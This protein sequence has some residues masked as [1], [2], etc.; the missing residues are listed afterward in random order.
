MRCQ[1]KICTLMECMQHNFHFS[2]IFLPDPTFLLMTMVLIIQIG[3]TSKICELYYLNLP[4]NMAN[5]HLLVVVCSQP[6][7]KRWILYK[8]VVSENFTNYFHFSYYTNLILQ[9][10][11]LHP[12]LVSWNYKK[13]NLS[14]CVA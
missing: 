11:H 5:K 10:F 1:G 12:F 7:Q 8:K 9:N 13:A 3:V 4:K 6:C 2:L 14:L